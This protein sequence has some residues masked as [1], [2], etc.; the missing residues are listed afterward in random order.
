MIVINSPSN[1]C[2]LSRVS[3]S[4]MVLI[5]SK[6]D[7]L[8]Q[9]TLLR[10]FNIAM[11]IGCHCP[12]LPRRGGNK[13]ANVRRNFLALM[14]ADLFFVVKNTAL[15]WA[16]LHIKFC[17]QWHSQALQVPFWS[18]KAP[19]KEDHFN[20][21]NQSALGDFQLRRPW[22]AHGAKGVVLCNRINSCCKW[23]CHVLQLGWLG[24]AIVLFK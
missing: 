12:P 17:I 1:S 20:Q 3:F 15:L 19:C 2:G 4:C 14:E 7:L 5:S 8:L 13:R 10:N 24:I 6:F 23:T 16:V 9:I 21:R 22:P 11:M 18:M